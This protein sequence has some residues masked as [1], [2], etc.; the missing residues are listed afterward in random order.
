MFVANVSNY[1]VFCIM[2]L[3]TMVSTILY[4]LKQDHH[5][6]YRLLRVLCSYLHMLSMIMFSFDFLNSFFVHGA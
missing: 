4:D 3:Y 5:P 2:T 6:V 1:S